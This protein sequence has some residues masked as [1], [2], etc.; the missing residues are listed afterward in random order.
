MDNSDNKLVYPIYDFEYIKAYKP[1]TYQSILL[2]LS[3]ARTKT[4]LEIEGTFLGI[5]ELS[6]GAS[7]SICLNEKFNQDIL[8]DSEQ[9]VDQPFYKIFITN[10]AQTGCTVRLFI[11][12]GGRYIPYY[13]TKAI[14]PTTPIAYYGIVTV[15]TT[16][17][18][19]LASNVRTRQVYLNNMSDTN[20]I[21]IGVNNLVTTIN[22][23]PIWQGNEKKFETQ[24]FYT[25]DIYGIASA[26]SELR[27][28]YNKE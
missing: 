6:A 9:Q 3:T 5:T 2:D 25:G 24:P 20:V 21:F 12:T 28:W 13:R 26:S 10:T 17:T 11:S 8:F 7:V 1:V 27:Y 16:A 15:L 22:G 23:I 14:L 18:L 19:I 4:P